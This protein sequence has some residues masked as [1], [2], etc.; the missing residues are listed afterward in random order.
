MGAD[1]LTYRPW[2]GQSHP[3]IYAVR[4]IAAVALRTIF[5][6]KLFWALYGLGL[7]IF[8]LFFFGQYLLAWS[9]SQLTES[10]VRVAG[11]RFEPAQL[12]SVFRGVLK[13]DGRTGE[14][15]FNFFWYQGYMIIIILALAGSILIGNDLQ[16]GSLPFYLSKP[17]SR[18]HY[19]LGKC[20]AL[21]VFINLLTTVPAVILFVQYGLLETSWDF[22]LDYAHLLAGI[23][24]YGLVLTVCLSLILVATASWVRRT[25]PLIM[26][27]TALFVFCRFLAAALVD[28]NRLHYDPKWRLIDLW[29]DM[30]LIGKS[31]LGLP[32]GDSQP[33]IGWAV[34]VLC[35]VC[36]L[37]LSYLVLRIRAVEIVP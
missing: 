24:G 4:P 29:N 9:E 2:R 36:G 31:F 14:M 10:T 11:A 25:V 33:E 18:S 1:L 6:R 32:L 13:L 3:P 37:S 26:T 28:Q 5:R 27:W 15:Y 30:N 12:V 22:F 34:L 20:L 16:Q 35:A 17:L 19:V 7:M 23:L 8:L 21:A